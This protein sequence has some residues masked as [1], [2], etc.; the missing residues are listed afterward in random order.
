MP[1]SV[2]ITGC[3]MGGAGSGIA[4]A[5]QARGL[6]VF[7]TARSMAKLAHLSSL[8]NV[9]CLQLDVT[10][11]ASIAKAVAIV[12]KTGDGTLKYLVNNAGVGMVMP[13]LD[14][15]IDEGKQMFEANFWGPVAMIKAFAPMIVEAKGT[16][17]NVGSGAGSLPF[18]WI[19]VYAASKAAFNL[20]SETLRLELEPLGVNVVTVVL[21]SVKTNFFS[22]IQSSWRLPLG[23]Y[24]RTMEEVM[25]DKVNGSDFTPGTIDG[26]GVG[27]QICNDILAGKKGNLYRGKD[28]WQVPFIG[29]APGFILDFISKDKGL[30]KQFRVGKN[31]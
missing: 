19:G 17:V 9:T 29:L 15:D 16:I 25:I 10:S 7:A 12:N 5:F 1:D 8:P 20:L 22:D 14:T 18:I 27:K 6:H 2:L 21:G 23:S 31:E 30:I 11:S 13:I 4:L 24:C 26:E 28:A 3:T